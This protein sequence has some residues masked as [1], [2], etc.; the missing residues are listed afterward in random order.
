VAD[1]LPELIGLGVPDWRLAHLPGLL[2]KLLEETDSFRIDQPDGLTADEFHRVREV[3]GRFTQVCKDLAAYGIPET[4]NHG[5]LTDGN[6]LVRDG[7]II[8]F[9]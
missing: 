4:V 9:D 3:P 6:V 5:D 7:R 8:F 2:E 1:R